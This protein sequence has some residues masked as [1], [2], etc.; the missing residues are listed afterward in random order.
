[1]EILA[2]KLRPQ[3]L[4]DII[5]QQHLVGKNKIIRN[6]VNNKHLVS[7]ILYGK[8]GIG[9]TSI[10]YAIVKEIDKPYRM[11]NATIN[12]KQDI[13]IVLEEAKMN[14]EMIVIMDEVHRLNKDK[15]DILLPYIENGLITFIGLTTSNP[16]HKINP[17]IRS[18]CQIFE[19]KELTLSDI[20][21]G[22]DK[23][24][25]HLKDIII[26]EDAKNAIA[27]L[28]GGDLRY[29][30]NLLEV[31]YYGSS[32]KHITLDTIKAKIY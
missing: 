13:D 9:K 14:G 1:M 28:A 24:S 32:N 7:M 23:A 31:A 30:L 6:L 3:C 15:Q 25:K 11:L 26:D 17:A 8:P 19:L 29:A 16:Y 4:D 22:L 20:K 10:A 2:D 5:G 21:I 27:K 18:R 12:N